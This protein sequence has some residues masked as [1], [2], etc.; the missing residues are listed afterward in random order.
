MPSHR[1]ARGAALVAAIALAACSDVPASN[2]FDPATPPSQQQHG[3]VEG[4]LI[5]PPQF[6]W[7]RF[8]S[9]SMALQSTRGDVARETPILNG[10]FVFEAVPAGFCVLETRVPG[11]KAPPRDLSVGIGESIVLPAVTLTSAGAKRIEGVAKLAGAVDGGHQDIRVEALNTPFQA[12]TN[13]EGRYVLEV[14][15]G[16]SA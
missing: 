12:R 10:A 9:P 4:T 1:I 11:L 16:A 14:V 13:T 6:L 3:R 7:E 5:L 15:A 2:P 8:D